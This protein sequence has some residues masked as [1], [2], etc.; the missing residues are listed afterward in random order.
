MWLRRLLVVVVSTAGLAGTAPVA[1]FAAGTDDPG[2]PTI[3]EIACPLFMPP[4]PSASMEPHSVRDVR[5]TFLSSESRV[6]VNDLDSPATATFT[7]TVSQ[8]FSLSA[9][10]GVSL[11]KLLPFLTLNVS[12][13]I[14]SS[15]TTTI[16]VGASAPVPPHS[17]VVGEY[18]VLAYDVTYD[19]YLVNRRADQICYVSGGTVGSTVWTVTAPTNLQGWRVR[20]GP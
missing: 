9:S 10:G 15:T 2:P 12:A 19:V 4:G 17:S 7:S 20:P 5:T 11:T 8:T 16:G 1:A 3:V 13:S 14:T 18:G 6:V